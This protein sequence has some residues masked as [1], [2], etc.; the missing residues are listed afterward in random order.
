MWRCGTEGHGQWACWG[1]VGLDLG[2][3]VVFSNLNDSIILLSSFQNRCDPLQQYPD[4]NLKVSECESED[5][6]LGQR[7]SLMLVPSSAN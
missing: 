7:M 3:L 2:T 1:W 6:T 4:D 5:G